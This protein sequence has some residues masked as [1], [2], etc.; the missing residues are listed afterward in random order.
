MLYRP[1]T[2]PTTATIPAI[3]GRNLAHGHRT[4]TECAFIG[5][6]LHL[7]RTQLTSPTLK[8]CAA[9][10]GV[11]V[12][13]I[14]AAVTISDDPAAQ[15]AVLAGRVALLD[16]ARATPP[17]SLAAHFARSTPA[18]WLEAARTVGPAAVWDH[19]ITPL[20]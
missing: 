5:R 2:P 4:S 8:Q 9:L 1:S 10:A 15:S 7:N 16:A 11:S 18:D 3:T 13:Y 12:R 17:E 19:M 6:D 14:A 20:I